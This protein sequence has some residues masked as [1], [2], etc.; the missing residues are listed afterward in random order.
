LIKALQNPKIATVSELRDA[1][2]SEVEKLSDGLQKP[3][4]SNENLRFNFQ[5]K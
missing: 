4:V 3:V 2:N 1:V 5:L